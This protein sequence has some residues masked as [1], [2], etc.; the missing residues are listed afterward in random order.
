[1]S[2]PHILERAFELARSG[3]CVDA[4]EISRQLKREGF[5]QVDEHLSAPSVRR[6]LRDLCKEANH[7]PI[8]QT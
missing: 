7:R 4:S 6:Q 2:N 5:T 3:K 1:M 8:G